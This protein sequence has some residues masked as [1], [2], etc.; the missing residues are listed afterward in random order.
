M[1][2]IM[3]SLFSGGQLFEQGALAA[4][5]TPRRGVEYDP[6][7]AAVGEQ[8]TPGSSV[9]VADVC[10]LDFSDWEQPYLL[11]MSL[12]CTR[13]SQANP[14]AGESEVDIQAAEACVRAIRALRP[15][16]VTL[17]NVWQYAAF[18]SFRVIL[19]ALHSEGYA[20]DY[21]H[22]NAADYGVPQ[23]RRR[24]ILVASREFAPRRPAATHQE[25][26]VAQ[27]DLFGAALPAWNGWY[28]AIEDLLD[29]LPKSEFAPWQ[30]ARL[31]EV[32]GGD[33]LVHGSDM[34][35][36]PA[37]VAT[38]PAFTVMANG[39]GN[40]NRPRAFLVGSGNTN[41]AEPAHGVTQQS[42]GRVRAFIVEGAN[43]RTEERGG[44]GIRG[45]HE[46]VF[47]I[48]A[49]TSRAMPRAWL[50]L[51]RV[52]AM[53]PRALARFQSVPDSYQLPERAGLACK[54]IGNGVPPLLVQRVLEA[55]P[56]TA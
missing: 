5:Y 38:D 53:T 32:L 18:E 29:T 10:A 52:V 33:L 24:L 56:W 55:Q 23:T 44:L 50:A 34:R 41:I 3:H 43:A 25:R 12:V 54:V 7:I 27:L 42:G 26:P 16:M 21:W 31:P 35:S 8:N 46:P 39:N 49:S 30:L 36:M 22:L 11:H 20:F 51:G 19:G 6:A 9:T 4:G 37:L 17:E 14:N 2:R 40:G 48:G 15:V 13:A 1:T 47:T 28:A 45:K